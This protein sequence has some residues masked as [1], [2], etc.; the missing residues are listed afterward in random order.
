MTSASPARPARI[1]RV[2]IFVGIVW[3]VASSFVA[4]DLA[5]LAGFG[6]LLNTGSGRALALS[7]TVRD[8]TTCV[9]STPAGQPVPQA[10]DADATAWVLGVMAGIQS[11]T[12]R[13]ETDGAAAG[14]VQPSQWRLLARDRSARAGRNVEELAA[15]LQV[16]PPRRFTGG[17]RADANSAYVTAVESDAAGTARAIATRYSASACH[18]YKMGA[19]W[20]YASEVRIMLPGERS[21]FAPEIA[22][23]ARQAGLPES[24]WAP[25]IAASPGNATTAELAA[26]GQQITQAITGYLADRR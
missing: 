3:A 23:H 25:A 13:W 18:F 5:A 20:G 7:A 17:L 11:L 22:H 4:F 1:A 26:Q 19:Y 2:A 14:D 21:I 9:A 8:S 6:L 10:R 15:E 16:P 12:A 24:L